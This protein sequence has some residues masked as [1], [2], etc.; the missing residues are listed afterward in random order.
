MKDRTCKVLAFLSCTTAPAIGLSCAS[1]TV[2]CTTLSLSSSDLFF[3]WANAAEAKHVRSTTATVI[4]RIIVSAAIGFYRRHWPS[5]S[6]DA[7]SSY[8]VLPDKLFP[9]LVFLVLFVLVILVREALFV[10]FFFLISFRFELE[11]ANANDLKI[12]STFITTQ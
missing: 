12:G 7:C 2:P 8:M 1:V 5:G 4:R 9:I 6:L 11:G 3:C 10:L